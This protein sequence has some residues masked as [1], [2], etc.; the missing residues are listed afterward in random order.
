MRLL[1]NAALLN[2]I[3]LSAGTLYKWESS[4]LKTILLEISIGIAFIQFFIITV[5]S[6]IKPCFSAGRRCRQ[7]QSYDVIDGNSDDD[8]THERVEDSE[9]ENI[10]LSSKEY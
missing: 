7:K 4:I 10:Y 8:I 5:W 6:L 2:L 3:I 9:L 1:E